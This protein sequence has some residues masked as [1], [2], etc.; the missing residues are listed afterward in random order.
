MACFTATMSL[1][2]PSGGILRIGP[3]MSAAIVESC[4]TRTDQSHILYLDNGAELQLDDR[5]FIEY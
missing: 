2:Q 4:P 5:Q 1:R 3:L